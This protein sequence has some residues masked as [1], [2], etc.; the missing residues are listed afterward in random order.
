MAEGNDRRKRTACVVVLGDL[1]RRKERN[2][3]NERKKEW[4]AKFKLRKIEWV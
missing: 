2:A 1:G 3:Q 4:G